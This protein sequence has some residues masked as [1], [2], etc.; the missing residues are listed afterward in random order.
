MNPEGLVPT[1]MIFGVLP[2]F[3]AIRTEFPNQLDRMRALNVARQGAE[4]V[5]SRLRI[6]Q[7]LKYRIPVIDME[8]LKRGSKV[9]IYREKEKCWSQP[10]VY[11]K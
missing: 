1:F 8:N 6:T 11:M 10:L 9:S 3:P 4:T 5:F 7:A 2:R